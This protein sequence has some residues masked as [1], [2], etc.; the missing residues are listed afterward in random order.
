[1]N[2]LVVVPCLNEA[3]AL[4]GL[5]SRMPE[6]LEVLVV[7]DGSSDETLAVA[8][9]FGAHLCHHPRRLGVGASLREAYQWSLARGYEVTVVMAGNGKDDPSDVPRLLEPIEAGL[10]DFVQGS[11]WL[12]TEVSVGAMPLYRRLAT[13]LHPILFSLVSGHLVTDSTNGFRAIH[14]RLLEQIDLTVP[15]NAY[16]FEPWLHRQ[17]LERG[18]SAVEVPVDKVYPRADRQVT[19]MT[20]VVS[21]WQ[22]LTPLWRS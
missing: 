18:A 19:R 17:V 9:E 11:R 15:L 2:V 22:M 8:R 3:V 13:R 7:D 21:W 1:M 4:R 20:P 16:E 14:R 10:A 12:G 5:L 6:G